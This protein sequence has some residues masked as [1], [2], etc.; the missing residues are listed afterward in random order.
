ML[1]NSSECRYFS[2]NVTPRIFCEKRFFLII[3]MNSSR[4]F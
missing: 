4:S 3:I 1:S 2:Y